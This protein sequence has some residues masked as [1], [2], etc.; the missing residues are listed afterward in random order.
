[1]NML[2]DQL[3]NAAEE[4]R[5]NVATTRTRPAAAVHGR[6]Q[7]RRVAMGSMIVAG[8]LGLSGISAFIAQDS[9]GFD[10][11][12]G[13]TTVTSADATVVPA[14]TLP[15]YSLNLDEWQVGEVI[16]R[17]DAHLIYYHRSASG[18]EANGASIE[19]WSHAAN[20]TSDSGLNLATET[21]PSRV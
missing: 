21:E 18:D 14:D 9:N 7:R 3:T 8:V 13:G 6:V 19:V 4:A 20:D 17:P 1:M 11:G 12:A 16:D 2:E 10:A 15:Q 5:H